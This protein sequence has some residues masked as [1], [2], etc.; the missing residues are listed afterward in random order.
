MIDAH[1]WPSLRRSTSRV[2][3]W[4]SA[5][6]SAIAKAAVRGIGMTGTVFADRIPVKGFPRIIVA[7]VPGL[8]YRV[9]MMPTDTA[10]D[11]LAWADTIRAEMARR[12]LHQSHIA[13]A[14]GVSQSGV[15]ERLSAKV[16]FTVDELAAIAR[17]LGVDVR[18]LFSPVGVDRQSGCT[19]GQQLSLFGLGAAG[20]GGLDILPAAEHDAARR[21]HPT[22]NTPTA[23]ADE[24]AAVAV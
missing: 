5:R 8:S 10:P 2:A 9:Q 17:L 6:R 20:R 1:D 23:A 16:P 13:D 4:P 18:D 12:R 24:F 21:R 7:S 19:T 11:R 22:A 3:S 14:I 15:S